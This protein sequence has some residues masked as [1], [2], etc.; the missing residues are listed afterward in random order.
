MI[1]MVTLPSRRALDAALRRLR[2][3]SDTVSSDPEGLEL[4]DAATFL[5]EVSQ[6][7]DL[8]P[9]EAIIETKEKQ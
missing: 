9:R 3:R 1:V 2:I 4:W 6:A 7:A 5:Q 8:L